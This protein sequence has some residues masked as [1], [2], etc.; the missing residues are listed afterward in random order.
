MTLFGVRFDEQQFR[1]SMY[2]VGGQTANEAA[3]G[4]QTQRIQGGLGASGGLR[5][6]V[7]W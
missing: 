5:V 2:V 4:R 3:F 1:R 6:L 7:T